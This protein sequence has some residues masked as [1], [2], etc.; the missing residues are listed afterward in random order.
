MD[1]Q[2][3]DKENDMKKKMPI[4][5]VLFL[6]VLVA[7]LIFAVQSN[8][9]YK[10][11]GQ[12]IGFMNRINAHNS[13]VWY[14]GNLDPGDEITINYKKVTEFTDETIGDPDNQYLYR[15]IVIFDFDGTMDISDEELLLIKK[16][17]E[18]EYYD[19]IYYGTAHME[20]FRSCGYFREMDSAEKG[21]TYNGSYWRMRSGQES[22]LNPYLLTGNW[23]ED[24]NMRYDTTDEHMMWKFLIQYMDTIIDESKVDIR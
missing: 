19:M 21:F 9:F 20:Q 5:I 17:C 23:T 7:L 4:F 10:P 2:I 8:W 24:D 14:Y 15:T 18:N 13:I 1:S 12:Q 16:Y 11:D 3:K 6:I 22:Y